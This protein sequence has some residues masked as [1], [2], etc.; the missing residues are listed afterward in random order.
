MFSITL[1]EIHD[2]Q[3][4]LYTS[5]LNTKM[6]FQTLHGQ[7][8]HGDIKLKSLLL[9]ICLSYKLQLEIWNVS[10]NGTIVIRL[11]QLFLVDFSVILYSIEK[12]NLKCTILTL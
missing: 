8:L 4:K 1:Q 6:F 2:V 3:K 7:G 10:R 9:K 5:I 11:Q 12:S